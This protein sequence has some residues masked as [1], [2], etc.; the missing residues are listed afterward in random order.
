M[1]S[2]RGAGLCFVPLS[3]DGHLAITGGAAGTF[4][5]LLCECLLLIALGA[6]LGVIAGSYGDWEFNLPG[7]TVSGAAAPFCVPSGHARGPRLLHV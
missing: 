4:V 7:A 3:V 2:R 5:F 6:H 1:L